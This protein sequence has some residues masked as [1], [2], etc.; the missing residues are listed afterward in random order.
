VARVAVPA[1]VLGGGGTNVLSV[2]G[3]SADNIVVG[4][5]GKDVLTGGTGQ[6]VL[7]GGGNADVLNAGSGGDVLIGGRTAYDAN[8]SALEAVLA[9]WSSG[10]AYQTRVQKLFGNGVTPLNAS[11]VIN[12][13]AVN[14]INGGLGMDWFWLEGA[15][16]RF[17]GEEGGEVVTVK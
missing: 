8:L 11:T 5:A 14:Q 4:G 15:T 13:G 9:E 3:S 17:S 16:D 6:D 1:I 2:V 7:I 10:D 12:D